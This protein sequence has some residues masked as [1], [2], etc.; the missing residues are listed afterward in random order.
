MFSPVS[1]P[2]APRT[3]AIICFSRQKAHRDHKKRT[4]TRR[5]IIDHIIQLCCATSEIHIFIIFISDHRIHGI[6]CL[7]HK[8]ENRTSNCQINEWRDHAIRCIFCYGLHR[9]LCHSGS[10]EYLCIP[11]NDHRH[12]VARTFQIILFQCLIHFHAFYFQA[13]CSKNLI[14]HNAF[15]DTSGEWMQPISR[16]QNRR[17]N[18][19]GQTYHQNRHRHTAPKLLTFF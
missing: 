10:I 18:N 13:F 1:S 9:S 5:N 8:P 2:D 17:R 7:I 19:S 14:C 6:D 4:D 16:H 11:P 12:R 3:F 15:D